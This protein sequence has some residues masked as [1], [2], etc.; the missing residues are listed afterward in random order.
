MNKEEFYNYLS[1]PEL[2][3]NIS[4]NDIDDIITEFPYFQ[5]AYILKAKILSDKKSIK[6]DNQIKTTSLYA[7]DRRLLYEFIN[8]K[9][10]A[11]EIKKETP[12]E[13]IITEKKVEEIKLEEKQIE[14]V[15]KTPKETI[16]QLEKIEIVKEKETIEEI[17]EIVEKKPIEKTKQKI[18]FVKINAE[19]LKSNVITE[20]II[21]PIITE[22]KEKIIVESTEIEEPIT[23]KEEAKQEKVQ[24]IEQKIEEK[25]EEEKQEIVEETK[26]EKKPSLVIKTRFSGKRTIADEVLDKL[27]DKIEDRE[28]ESI[29]DKILREA[30]ER[31]AKKQKEAAI[32]TEKEE[33]LTVEPKQEIVEKKSVE[34]IKQKIY[35]VKINVDELKSNKVTEDITEPIVEE[36]LPKEFSSKQKRK[37]YF[38]KIKIETPKEKVLDVTEPKEEPAK[39]SIEPE[40]EEIIQQ[41]SYYIIENEL[42]E[43]IETISPSSEMGFADWLNFVENRNE[44]PKEP[45]KNS[46]IDK[47]ISENPSISINVEDDTTLEKAEKTLDKGK[48]E[49]FVTE[50]LAN[51]YIKQKHFEKAVSAMEKLS[52]KYPQKSIYFA[53]R[54]KEIKNL[55]KE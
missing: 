11:Q 4:E 13:E 6:F 27:R 20:E 45:S 34:K 41:P 43:N 48:K 50:T 37:I 47:F 53:N 7:L 29:A 9:Y 18:Y 15:E 51:I 24:K 25:P 31:K 30:K 17:K 38:I 46:L 3:S 16:K 22:T 8:T 55:I 44:K 21:E 40:L 36:T 19:K 52:L 35:F 5:T 32:I 1:N 26:Q 54:I 49:Q 14:T 33:K 12:K 10:S 28:G 23:I 39:A 2:L 42:E